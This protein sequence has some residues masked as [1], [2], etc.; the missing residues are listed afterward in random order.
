MRSLSTLAA[1]LLGLAATAALV[2]TA[3]S[4]ISAGHLGGGEGHGGD[5]TTLGDLACIEGLWS[6][7]SAKTSNSY[8]M[9]QTV[10]S[11]SNWTGTHVT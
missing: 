6:R 11:M 5:R 1:L 10:T 7:K 3:V 9:S 2:V 4:P 8:G